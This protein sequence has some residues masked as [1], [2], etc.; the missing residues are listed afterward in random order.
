[1]KRYLTIHIIPHSGRLKELKLSY[2]LLRIL[3]FL[4]ILLVLGGGWL[5]F[6]YGDIYRRAA[7]SYILERRIRELE[8]E[9]KKLDEL[10]LHLNRYERIA[11]SLSMLLQLDLSPKEMEYEVKKE[12]ERPKEDGDLIRFV[13]DIWPVK[14]WVSKGFSQNH[15][16]IDISAPSG[17]PIVST[18]D[19]IVKDSRWDQDLGW[20]LEIENDK[21]FHIVYGH[22]MK[23][24][25][26]KG[27]RVKKG[28]KVA[29]VGSTGRS[30]APH[31][32]YEIRVQGVPVDPMQYLKKEEK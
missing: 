30:S 21:G 8:L 27:E 6:K 28:E 15:P 5:I 26:K 23:N 7:L 2:G 17:T 32:H 24:L 12:E 13:P 1:M 29:L 10:S 11:K 14:G 4:L 18:I 22:N 25:V 31:L 9:N 19:G 16:G 20:V 3:L